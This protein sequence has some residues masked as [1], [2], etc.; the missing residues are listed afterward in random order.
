MRRVEYG[1]GDRR[2]VF[3]LGWGNRPEHDTVDW[4]LTEL[5]DAG[6]RTTVF[7]LPRTIT[8]FESE[9]LEPVREYVDKPDS[10]RLLIR[11]FVTLYRYS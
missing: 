4:L 7:E 9:Y 1:D 2:L 5:V 11:S 8:D 3:V 6:Y 10:Y